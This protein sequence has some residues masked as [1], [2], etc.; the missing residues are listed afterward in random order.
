MLRDI[1]LPG[2]QNLGPA[3]LR[4]DGSVVL[5]GTTLRGSGGFAPDADVVVCALSRG[6]SVEWADT[7]GGK[8]RDSVQSAAVGKDGSVYVSVTITDDA[9]STPAA[10][11]IPQTKPVPGKPRYFIYAWSAEGKRLWNAEGGGQFMA[12]GSDGNVYCAGSYGLDFMTTLPPVMPPSRGETNLYIMC[13]NRDGWFQ[14]ATRDGGLG[15]HWIRDFGLIDGGKRA[16]LVGTSDAKSYVA[17]SVI[18]IRSSEGAFVVNIP[19]RANGNFQSGL[20]PQHF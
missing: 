12:V 6:G 3:L 16:I 17:G 13:F 9:A 10:G 8:W 4:G 19:L 20:P 1:A 15:L 14:W 2:S 11:R 18:D 7:I 5:T